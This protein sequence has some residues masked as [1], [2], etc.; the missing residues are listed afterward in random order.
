MATPN[1]P[2]NPAKR[3][4]RRA[5]WDARSQQATYRGR[6]LRFCTGSPYMGQ[7]K[8]VRSWFGRLAAPNIALTRTLNGVTKVLLP[9]VEEEE[10]PP[11]EPPED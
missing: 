5:A 8:P 1:P 11:P 2:E 9:V 6:T 3:N 10:P 4:G 7:P